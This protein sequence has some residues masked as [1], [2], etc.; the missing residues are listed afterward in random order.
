M[1]RHGNPFAPGQ[2]LAA[3]DAIEQKPEAVSAALANRRYRAGLP[4]D[5]TVVAAPIF[6][7][8]YPRGVVVV[9]AEPPPALA[10]AFDQ[11]RGDR[12][13]AL[14]IAIAIGLLVG[15][16]AS[17]LIA[18]RVRRLA[19]AAEQ[20]AGG[21]FDAPLPPG[22]GDEIGDLTRSLDTMRQEL[23]KTFGM[24]ATER[25]RLSA[26]FD[27]LTE[28]VIVVGQGG[29]VRFANP[30]AE[31]LVRDGQPAAALVPPL[32]RAAERG[33]AEIPALSIEERIYGVQA[34]RVAGR[35]LRAAGGPGPYRGAQARRG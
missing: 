1:N 32:R 25:D 22:G 19:R 28:A 4:G 10:R 5:V 26:I 15:F 24:L 27:G 35:A 34:R 8:S 33:S 11:L 21:R 13:R 2:N 30:A 6:G 12:L 9:R 20:M 16:L 18:I 14:L 7:K 31:G 29:E 3:L 23:R 17:S